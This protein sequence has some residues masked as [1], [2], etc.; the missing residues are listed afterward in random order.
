MSKIKNKRKFLKPLGV[1]VSTLLSM[2]APLSAS[3]F[4][5][6]QDSVVTSA[7]QSIIEQNSIGKQNLLLVERSN[8]EFS[9]VGHYSHSSHG[10]HASH[11][12]SSR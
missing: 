11:Y 7:A 12:S 9:K 6:I 5:S 2:S 4:P 8:A 1:M 10:S 3:A